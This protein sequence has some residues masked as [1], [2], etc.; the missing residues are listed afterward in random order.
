MKM[1][2]N[3]LRL[4][5]CALAAA[6]AVTVGFSKPALAEPSP[7]TNQVQVSEATVLV[8]GKETNI[9]SFLECS[10]ASD[11]TSANLTTE[12]KERFEEAFESM[13]QA[14][15]T[16]ATINT[17]SMADIHIVNDADGKIKEAVEKNGLTVSLKVSGGIEAGRE[18][19][20]YHCTSTSDPKDISTWEQGVCKAD[21]A[22]GMVEFTIHKLS[23]VAIVADKPAGSAASGTPATGSNAA[24][25]NALILWA[26]LGGIAVCGLVVIAVYV[27]KSRKKS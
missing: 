17:V 27:T 26:V 16:T 25:H 9:A 5:V 13:K 21:P 1:K 7:A 4:C 14:D 6:T 18:Y 2:K 19:R 24:D 22:T 20:F 8:D 15:S 11:V 3:T 23:P 12:E 10:I